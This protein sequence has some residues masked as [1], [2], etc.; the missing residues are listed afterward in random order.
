MAGA[1]CW[2]AR[3]S[4]GT[5]TDTRGEI[6]AVAARAAAGPHCGTIGRPYRLKIGPF[7]G[8]NLKVCAD[9]PR[10][11]APTSLI[12]FI[13]RTPPVG[14]CREASCAPRRVRV[15]TTQAASS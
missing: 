2:S 14:R 13:R 12:P 4:G 15:S 10:T 9:Q 11:L 6:G 3:R 8:Y 7:S 5:L 1:P